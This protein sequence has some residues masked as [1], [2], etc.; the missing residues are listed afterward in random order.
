MSDGLPEMETV[1]VG[2]TVMITS[3]ELEAH[4]GFEMVQRR[5][6]EEPTTNPVTPEVGEEGVVTVAVPATTD[7]KPEPTAGVFP[8]SV[9]VVTPQSS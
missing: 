5:V 9:E 4:G 8:A 7:H 1:G 2:F 6:A 3:S